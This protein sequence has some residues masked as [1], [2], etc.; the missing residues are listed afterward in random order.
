MTLALFL[1]MNILYKS[2]LWP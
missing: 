1:A 2:W